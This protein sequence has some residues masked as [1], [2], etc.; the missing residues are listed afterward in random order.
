MM[1]LHFENELHYKNSKKTYNTGSSDNKYTQH[2]S[3][4]FMFVWP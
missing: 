1:V 2:Y 3:V 4:T